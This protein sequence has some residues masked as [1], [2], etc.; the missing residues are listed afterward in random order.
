MLKCAQPPKLQGKQGM[1][2]GTIQGD[3]WIDFSLFTPLIANSSQGLHQ[4]PVCRRENG[5]PPDLLP[6]HGPLWIAPPP[7]D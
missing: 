6:L 1:I 2:D 7:A 5:V 3:K 4:K